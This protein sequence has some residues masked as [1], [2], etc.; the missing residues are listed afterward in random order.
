MKK[1]YII[2]FSLSVLVT[3]ALC[4]VAYML[5][6]P[7]VNVTIGDVAKYENVVKEEYKFVKTKDISKEFLQKDY[8]ITAAQIN[9][10]LNKNQYR[11]GNTDPFTI[12]NNTG[13]S[14]GDKDNTNNS[15][16]NTGNNTTNNNGGQ[17][18]PSIPSK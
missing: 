1:I 8:T 13:S 14:T 4:V 3:F 16:N 10:F 6:L 11:P 15:N 7:Q 2:T 9:G 12:K 18:K 17:T 5:M